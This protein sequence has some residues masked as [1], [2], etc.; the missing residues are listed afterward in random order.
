MFIGSG[1][2]AGP[3][4]PALGLIPLWCL[5]LFVA[6]VLTGFV[7]HKH[8]ETEKQQKDAFESVNILKLLQLSI[9]EAR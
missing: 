5:T 2:T 9:F 8:V 3:L 1:G 6:V 7:A 4:H